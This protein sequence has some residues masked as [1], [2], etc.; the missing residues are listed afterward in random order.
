MFIDMLFDYVLLRSIR[1]VPCMWPFLIFNRMCVYALWKGRRLHTV[2]EVSVVVVERD[3]LHPLLS[4]QI[5]VQLLGAQLQPRSFIVLKVGR[6]TK[7]FGLRRA[8][9]LSEQRDLT[10]GRRQAGSLQAEVLQRHRRRHGG[11]FQR[12]VLG[13]EL[14]P[15]LDVGRVHF[16]ESRTAR[17]ARLQH[18][19]L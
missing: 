18:V 15:V 17:L 12:A 9:G 19:R 7:F 8:Q 6:Q 5:I 2:V 11:G 13:E 4:V 3:D 16:E 10:R 1:E 14:L